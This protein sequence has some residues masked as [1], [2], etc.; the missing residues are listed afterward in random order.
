MKVIIS[1]VVAS[2]SIFGGYALAGGQMYLLMQ[3]A[4]YLIIVGGAAAAFYLGTGS[5]TMSLIRRTLKNS[6]RRESQTDDYL[7]VM[8]LLHDLLTKLSREGM[9]AVEADIERPE[10][11][12]LFDRYP[13]VMQD[14]ATLEFIT[15]YLRMM[16]TSKLTGS[17][18]QN[19]MDDEINTRRKENDKASGALYRTADALPAFG[20]MAAVMGVVHVMGSV[21]QVSNAELG[22]MIGSA[23]VGTFVGVLFAYAYV[24]PLAQF[25]ENR[26][27]ENIKKLECIQAI[28]VAHIGHGFSPALAVEF[29]RKTLYSGVRPSFDEM[30]AHLRGLRGAGVGSQSNSSPPMGQS[31]V[32][33]AR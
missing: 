33:Q 19:A 11:S 28:L 9:I 24:G 21:G 10:S 16:V 15:D 4:E 25:V 26:L 31:N 20:I 6:F 12:P 13:S 22:V 2:L 30:E 29:G 7:Q 27:S 14:R 8:G 5:K 18:I 3:P 17:Q 1:F 32:F 23:L